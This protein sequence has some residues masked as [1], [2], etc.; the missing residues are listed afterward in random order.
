MTLFTWFL[1]V[2]G[3]IGLIGLVTLVWVVAWLTFETSDLW[4]D[5]ISKHQ[6]RMFAEEVKRMRGEKRRG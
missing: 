6:A 2:I 5:V 3:G 1:A 4:I